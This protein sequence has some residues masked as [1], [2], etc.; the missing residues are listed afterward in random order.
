MGYIRQLYN[1]N[2]SRYGH[3]RLA[4]SVIRDL[5]GSNGTGRPLVRSMAI[6]TVW[7]TAPS[8]AICEFSNFTGPCPQPTTRGTPSS[9][10]PSGSFT[11]LWPNRRPRPSRSTGSKNISATTDGITT[12]RRSLTLLRLMQPPTCPT[13]IRVVP[14]GSRSTAKAVR[15]SNR[16]LCHLS[17]RPCTA[18]PAARGRQRQR[19]QG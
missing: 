14:G 15:R 10:R 18:L 12:A 1:C 2:W 17:Q 19:V 3:G 7:G 5:R 11:T 8:L 16:P 9:L 4:D 6:R 13:T